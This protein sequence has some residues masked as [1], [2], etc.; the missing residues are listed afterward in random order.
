MILDLGNYYASAWPHHLRPIGEGGFEKESFEDWWFRN[1]NE[2]AHLHPQICEQ[3][4]YRHWT[5]SR[6]DFL[7]LADLNWSLEK[8]PAERIIREVHR[9][10]AG[11]LDPTF[12]YEVFRAKPGHTHPT[13][14]ALDQGTWDYPILV[15]S[16]PAGIMDSGKSR[17][18]VRT[19]LVE[20]H[21]RQRYF[22]A[23]YQRGEIAG[24]HAVFILNSPRVQP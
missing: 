24:D 10:F 7:P 17:P 20:G 6:F 18:Y 22:N 21:Q 3:W 4:V 13:A 8:W 1:A 15:L 14:K 5:H 12:D 9:A 16:T 2:L 23:L 19:V 11:D